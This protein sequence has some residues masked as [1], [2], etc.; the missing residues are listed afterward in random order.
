MCLHICV[1]KVNMYA[2]IPPRHPSITTNADRSIDWLFALIASPYEYKRRRLPPARRVAGQWRRTARLHVC[3]CAWYCTH[4]NIFGSTERNTKN[5]KKQKK[6]HYVRKQQP[7]FV[8]RER[9]WCSRVT[10]FV[11]LCVCATADD[12]AIMKW[13]RWKLQNIKSS[14]SVL[15]L[16]LPSFFL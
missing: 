2:C 10:E 7:K 16:I 9:A 4:Q 3:V 13:N 6:K 11:C 5:S 12:T 15:N 1:Y 14:G 8:V